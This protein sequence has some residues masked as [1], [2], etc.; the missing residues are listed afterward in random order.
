MNGQKCITRM[1]MPYLHDKIIYASWG[2]SNAEGSGSLDCYNERRSGDTKPEFR[3][4][5]F[6][7]GGFSECVYDVYC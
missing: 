2:D 6:C 7:P 1:A 3:A 5:F 4:V